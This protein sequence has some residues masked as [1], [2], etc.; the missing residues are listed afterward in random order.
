MTPPDLETKT[1]AEAL[2]LKAHEQS[3]Q[4]PE[5]S[6]F[7]RE[8]PWRCEYH[9]SGPSPRLKVF[10]GD[11]CV[12]EEAVQNTAADRRSLELKRVLLESQRAGREDTLLR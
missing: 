11:S 6:P 4:S 10:S 8:G 1:L 7:W 5:R 9:R 12:H 2:L 3:S